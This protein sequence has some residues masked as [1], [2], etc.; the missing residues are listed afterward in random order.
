MLPEIEVR[1]RGWDQL[2]NPDELLEFALA[3]V[4]T[5][6]LAAGIAFHPVNLATRRT[7][8]DFDAPRDLFVYALIGMIVGFLIMHHGYLIG[9]VLFGLG[10]LLR[11][12]SVM[13]RL[14]RCA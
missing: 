1:G 10:G 5:T 13:V 9:F 12:K 14:I 11:F 7:R 3:L 6:V 8:A 4:E 2:R